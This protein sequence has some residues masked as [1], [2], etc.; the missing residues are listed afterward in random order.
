MVR[1]SAGRCQGRRLPKP[2]SSLSTAWTARPKRA[3]RPGA[4]P[5]GSPF[6]CRRPVAA[7]RRG[8]R[9][10][11]GGARHRGRGEAK[12][13]EQGGDHGT[14]IVSGSDR[15]TTCPP[16]EVLARSEEHTSELQSHLNLVCRLLLEKKN[17]RPTQV[18]T[19]AY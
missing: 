19:H 10:R 15:S 6:A 5:A 2:A 13:L 14:A 8:S 3:G 18:P 11:A 9:G 7:A 1:S 12:Q 4:A 17:E 16:D